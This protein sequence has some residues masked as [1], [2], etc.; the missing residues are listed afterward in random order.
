MLARHNI[1]YVFDHFSE[2]VDTHFKKLV[3][4]S[5]DCAVDLVKEYLKYKEHGPPK[6]KEEVIRNKFRAWLAADTSTW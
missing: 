5:P 2:Y 1:T 3:V 6:V 4:S